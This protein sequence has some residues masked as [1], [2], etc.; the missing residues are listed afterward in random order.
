MVETADPP[1]W[2]MSRAGARAVRVLTN[3][4]CNQ[5][6]RF[7]D[8]RRSKDERNFLTEAGARVDAASDA[9]ELVVT[10]GE[11][12]MRRDL[13]Q[14]VAR[15]KASRIVLETNATLID[16]SR[17]RALADAGLTLA[18]VHLPAWGDEADAITRDPGGF[19]RAIEGIHALSGAGVA[20]DITTPVVRANAYSLP[21][22]PAQICELPVGGW[23]LG[24]PQRGPSPDTRLP[25]LDAVRVIARAH[26]AAR[27]VALPT[28][29]DP[30]THFPPCLFE[31]PARAAHLYSLTPGGRDRD[32]F[33]RV[34]TCAT[35]VAADRCPGVA[36][37][38][39]GE[40]LDQITPIVRDGV[41]R[42]LSVIDSVA[43]QVRRELF[44]DEIARAPD[45]T[46]TRVRTVRVAFSC[47]QSCDFCF[48][49]THLPAPDNADIRAAIVEA[50]RAGASVA[51]SGGEPTLVDAL[52]EWVELAK[53][54]GA[55]WVE[56]QT[57]A[58]RLHHIKGQTALATRLDSAGVDVCFVSLHASHAVLSDAITG[59]PGTFDQTVQGLDACAK[60]SMKVR[61]NFVFCA[62]NIDD[63]PSWV[64]WVAKRWKH[65][66]G[67][68]E[69][70]VSFVAASTDL[71]PRTRALIPRYTDVLPALLEGLSLADEHGLA[72]G[73]FDSMC[74]IPLCLVPADRVEPFELAA[75]PE[76]YAGGEVRTSG[77][78]NS[79]SAQSRCFGLR[80]GYAA[81]HGTDELRPFP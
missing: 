76:G 41:R 28:R 5:A 29:L 48:V 60:T 17:A 75:A 12:T 62:L 54:E 81:L 42:R 65:A 4:S 35:C 79:C 2:G 61:L 64:T 72:V 67:G 46:T 80:E 26:A 38:A 20:I 32:G 7:C 63:F 30:H 69:L 33:A 18:R 45:G 43:D 13:E 77:P 24:V 56:L 39:P 31:Y 25:L 22:M 47:N 37:D 70:S 66:P 68:I 55:P 78:C 73:G 15:S 1:R 50:A 44:Q 34:S 9:A 8:A 21:S 57:N 53:R 14:L 3:R 11:P 51:L 23:V 16:A 10:G 52:P 58:T 74:G 59:A 40:V 71:V 49:S 19:D 6:C 36:S 27:R